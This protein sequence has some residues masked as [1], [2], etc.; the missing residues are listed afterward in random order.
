MERDIIGPW[1]RDEGLHP[2]GGE[3]MLRN[4]VSPV[5]NKTLVDASFVPRPFV[6][7]RAG[8]SA[9]LQVIASQNSLVPHYSAASPLRCKTTGIAG[10]LVRD[11]P[12]WSVRLVVSGLPL[13][14]LEIRYA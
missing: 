10:T 13:F 12:V 9:P 11:S 2:D 3:V 5:G 1:E 14:W 7:T 8:F 4:G 6:R